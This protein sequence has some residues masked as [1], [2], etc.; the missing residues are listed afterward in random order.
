[1]KYVYPAI[2]TPVEDLRGYYAV[3]FP[4]IKAAV[5]QGKNLYDAIFLAEDLLNFALAYMEDDEEKIPV[6]TDLKSIKLDDAKS[7][8]V[9]V[10]ADT[11]NYRNC[12]EVFFGPNHKHGRWYSP[13]TDTYFYIKADSD[14]EICHKVE[15]L[16][17]NLAGV[18]NEQAEVKN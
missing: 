8:V 17:R 4:D 11:E 13:H 10:I 1:M 7:F 2:F 12:G 15:Q 5:T 3:E 6:P 9:P 14:E 16:I 18:Y